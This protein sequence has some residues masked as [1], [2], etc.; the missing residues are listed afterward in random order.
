MPVKFRA[1]LNVILAFSL[2]IPY[3]CKMNYSFTG[4]SI[5]PEIKTVSVQ[6]FPN[7]APGGGNPTLSQTFTE[8]LKDRFVSQTNLK[9]LERNG[10]LNFGG[11]ITG[12]SIQPI[13]IQGNETAASNRLTISV[14]VKFT[15]VKN[16]KQD[17]ETVFSRFVD[18]SSTK[19]L[20]TV[21]A[22]LIKQINEQLVNDIFNKAVSNW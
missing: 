20:S 5:S 17:F 16:E 21:E 13:A 22:E 8:K 11:S 19:S 15:N 14:N 4:A 18:F 1:V 12:Y 7:Y 6:Y 3:G 2:I 10:D 9:L